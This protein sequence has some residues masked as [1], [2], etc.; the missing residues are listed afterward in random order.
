MNINISDIEPAFSL[1]RE[2]VLKYDYYGSDKLFERVVGIPR[3]IFVSASAA[4]YFRALASS[5]PR[6]RVLFEFENGRIGLF[7]ILKYIKA[8]TKYKLK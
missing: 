3:R 2:H 6:E 1:Y 7:W 8:W 5:V 4:E